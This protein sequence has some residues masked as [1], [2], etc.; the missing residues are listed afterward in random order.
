MQ[1]YLLT[2]A[3]SLTVPEWCVS[4]VRSL[5]SFRGKELCLTFSE[6][7]NSEASEKA[8]GMG[9]QR[10]WSGDFQLFLSRG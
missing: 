10:G 7:E 1:R 4:R 5:V 2:A 8:L 9:T 6:M 3:A